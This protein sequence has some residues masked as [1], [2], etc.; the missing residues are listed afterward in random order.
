VDPF[1]VLSQWRY[2]SLQNKSAIGAQ[3]RGPSDMRLWWSEASSFFANNAT[4]WDFNYAIVSCDGSLEKPSPPHH[5]S[6]V[7]FHPKNPALHTGS[8]LLPRYHEVKIISS[9]E[10]IL[11]ST[12]HSH[13]YEFLVW[14]LTLFQH[15][16]YIKRIAKS[17]RNNLKY[18]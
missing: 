10:F 8:L 6:I 11:S 1:V 9:T 5:Y 4:E 2:L 17:Q 3:I 15:V 7:G 12:I 13:S 14:Q 16:A 18:F